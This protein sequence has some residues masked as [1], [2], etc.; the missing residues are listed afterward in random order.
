M[1]FCPATI[2]VARSIYN[3]IDVFINTKTFVDGGST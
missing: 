1:I 3:N 2:D